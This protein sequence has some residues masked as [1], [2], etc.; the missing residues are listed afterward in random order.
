MRQSLSDDAEG[1]AYLVSVDYFEALEHRDIERIESLL[2]EEFVLRDG[3]AL[4]FGTLERP[5]YLESVAAMLDIGEQV[6]FGDGVEVSDDCLL[7]TSDAA[8]E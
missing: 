8:D 2:A 1:R 4:G 7:Y 6:A 5:A 3:R